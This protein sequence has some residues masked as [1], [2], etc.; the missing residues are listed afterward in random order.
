MN[1]NIYGPIVIVC[2][3]PRKNNWK[4]QVTTGFWYWNR[5]IRSWLTEN[6][7]P[8]IY[9]H[10]GFYNRNP[11]CYT[12]SR[13][14]LCCSVRCKHVHCITTNNLNLVKTSGMPLSLQVLTVY[15]SVLCAEKPGKSQDNHCSKKKAWAAN[16]A[17][18]PRGKRSQPV[19]FFINTEK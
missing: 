12:N 3:R 1:F 18:R 10:T 8:Q 5:Y 19:C 13:T 9:T 15:I 16:W 7:T 11:A 6:S 4:R 2:K 17:D 14:F